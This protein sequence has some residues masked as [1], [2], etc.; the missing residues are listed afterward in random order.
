M[1]LLILT[2]PVFRWQWNSQW[3]LW[4]AYLGNFLRGIHPFAKNSPLELLA[5]F[6]P[7]SRSF[8][9]V[10]LYLGHFWS[11][12][13]EE[14]FYLIWPWVVFR[15]KKP[16]KTDLCM[17]RVR[18]VVCP[19]LRLVGNHVLPTYMLDQE[20]LYRWT[21]FRIDALLLG[22]LAALVNRGPSAKKLLVVARIGAAVATAVA[23]VWLVLTSTRLAMLGRTGYIY[24]EWKFTW[25]LLFY[26]SVR[27]RMSDRCC[28]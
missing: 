16:Q 15:V 27:R 26:R 14:Q 22:G 28:P 24:P 17:H 18:R 9:G 6:Q 23:V 4:P 25:G 21:P 2:Y 12:C 1:F 20:V 5:D 11:L 3:L 10:R 13:V 19:L 7:L 8:R